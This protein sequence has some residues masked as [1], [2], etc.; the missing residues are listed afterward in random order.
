MADD[1]IPLAS[2]LSVQELIQAL[3]TKEDLL[4]RVTGC[5]YDPEKDVNL[6]DVDAVPDDDAPDPTE[7]LNVDL[8]VSGVDDQSRAVIKKNFTDFGGNLVTDGIIKVGGQEIYAIFYRGPE[9]EF[10]SPHAASSPVPPPLDLPDHVKSIFAPGGQLAGIPWGQA[11]PTPMPLNGMKDGKMMLFKNQK[12][13][14]KAIVMRTDADI[15]TDGP[16]GSKA[17]DPSWGSGTSLTF[18]GGA[19]CDSRQFPGIVR[20]A[21]LLSRPYGLQ[22]GDFAYICYKG[23]VVACQVYDQGPDEKIGEISLFAAR[24]VG[25]VALNATEHWA[26]TKGNFADRDQDLVTICFPGSNPRGHGLSNPEIVSGTRHVFDDFVGSAPLFALPAVPAPPAAGTALPIYK[27]STWGA[28]KPKVDSFTPSKAL[29]IVVHNTEDPNRA[30]A[31][32]NR[33]IAAA[34]ELS[35]SIQ[36]SHMFERGFSDVGQHFTISRGGVI[37]EG[38]QGTLDAAFNGQVVRG[39][40]AGVTLFNNQWW[41]IELEGDYRVPG[42]MPPQPQQAALFQLCSWL[43]SLIQGF[44]ASQNIRVHRQVKPGG[45]DCPG[46][47]LDPAHMPDFLT[48]VR[49]NTAQNSAVPPPV[50]TVQ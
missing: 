38:R 23:K 12:G 37:M 4:L 18:P 22:M 10:P 34:F 11:F 40:H 49:T 5:R 46:H 3:R 48:D 9:P 50:P 19:C 1:T 17:I 44:D 36:H 26:A 42:A 29:G 28:L 25:G 43:A 13:E 41:G 45:T 15:D 8:F 32:R 35:R 31:A 16:G 7:F 30:P 2:T 27:R 20:S 6:F 47:L 39:A 14:V 33:E 24:Q 21:K